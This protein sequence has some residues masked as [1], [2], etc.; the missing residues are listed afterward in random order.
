M[1]ARRI[2]AAWLCLAVN[3]AVY[4]GAQAQSLF[5][6]IYPK[7][8]SVGCHGQV[9]TN[10]GTAGFD[11]SGVT[12]W[13]S[14]TAGVGFEGSSTAGGVN[15]SPGA[16]FKFTAVNGTGVSNPAPSC[17][18]A[19]C[20][21]KGCFTQTITFTGTTIPVHRFG[22]FQRNG[23]EFTLIGTDAGDNFICD[24]RAQTAP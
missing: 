7:V 20:I 10:S 5:P 22:C 15:L 23:A 3:C 1:L 18:R 12:Q 19:A 8:Y 6:T 13:N 2:V 16:S 24:G 21:P 14:A 4:A 11:S 17:T 9:P